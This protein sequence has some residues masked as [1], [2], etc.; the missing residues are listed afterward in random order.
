M[1]VL[2]ERLKDSCKKNINRQERQCNML[3]TSS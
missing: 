1:Q 3:L 2:L